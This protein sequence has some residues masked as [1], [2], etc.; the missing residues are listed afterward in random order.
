MQVKCP[1]MSPRKDESAHLILIPYSAVLAFIKHQLCWPLKNE[2]CACPP[3]GVIVFGVL[4]CF[5][6]GAVVN[7][8][9]FIFFS[10]CPNS[11]HRNEGKTIDKPQIT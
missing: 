1:V 11:V 5:F 2:A 4:F 8:D 7:A 10:S 3:L 9:Y 6:S